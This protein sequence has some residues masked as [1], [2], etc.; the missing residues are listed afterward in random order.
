MSLY[1]AFLGD[2]G[3]TLKI[4]VSMEVRGFVVDL[5]SYA[6]G[7]WQLGSPMSDAAGLPQRA[8]F[9]DALHGIELD[10]VDGVLDSAF[11]TLAAFKGSFAVHGDPV[12]LGAAT[13]ESHILARFGQPYW[14]DRSDG[15]TILFYEF[16]QGGVELQFEFPESQGLGFITLTRQGVLADEKQR[17]AYGCDKPWPPK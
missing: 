13:T 6:I 17:Q 10:T 16:E 3:K 12:G 5:G 9:N 4:P 8:Q 1:T 2:R 15:E 11:F 14:T 7:Q